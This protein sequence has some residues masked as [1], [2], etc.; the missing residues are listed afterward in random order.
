MTEKLFW[1]N[2][3]DTHFEAK[4][5]KITKNGIILD[6]T[7]FYPQG[8][9]QVSDKGKLDKEGFILSSYFYFFLNSS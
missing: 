5:I 7:L 3:Y 6:R 9:G 1:N 8:G 4:I 2:P